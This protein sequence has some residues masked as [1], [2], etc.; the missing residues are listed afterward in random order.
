MTERPMVAA[1]PPITESALPLEAP[2]QKPDS[3]ATGIDHASQVLTDPATREVLNADR[4]TPMPVPKEFASCDDLLGTLEKANVAKPAKFAEK[5]LDEQGRVKL[6]KVLRDVQ[7][8]KR[9]VSL[10]DHLVNDKSP[11]KFVEEFKKIP[12]SER[13]KV[14]KE[15]I[16]LNRQDANENPDQAIQRIQAY[17]KDYIQAG[18]GL[19]GRSTSVSAYELQTPGKLFGN[20]WPSSQVIS[21]HRV[22][23][24]YKVSLD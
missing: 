7:E 1:E 4:S 15:V 24:D 21:G 3:T 2:A 16:S 23:G 10:A 11:D 22:A 9:V 6:S 5:D 8:D 18:A 17:G 20:A 19:G 14:L 13:S 12:P